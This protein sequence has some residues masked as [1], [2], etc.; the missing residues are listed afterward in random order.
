MGGSRHLSQPTARR[1]KTSIADLLRCRAGS[2]GIEFALVAPV[3]FILLSG[4]YDITQ[5][6]IAQRRVI[7]TAQ[8]IVEIATELS[9][10][11]NQTMSLTTT[12]AYQAETAIYAL[13]PGLKSGTD[14]SRF[15]VTLS[16]AVFTAT[17]AGCVAGVN[18]TYVANTAWSTPLPQSTTPVTRPCGVI[19]QV[20]PTQQ[21]TINNL[22][23]AGM[24]GLQ[25]I[26]IA[27]V[28][29]IYQPLFTGFVVGPVTL[30][31]TAFL[32]PRTGTAAQYIEYD[33]ANAA[34][35]PAICPGYL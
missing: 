29:Y 13:I 22:P 5:L 26:V 1:K 11:P 17:P 24:T 21:T 35:D 7:V 9:I 2:P 15:F 25:S 34:T 19:A 27:D 4:A 18:C 28:S 10:Q 14:T 30:Q 16:A 33:V 6:L 23:T 31:R 32:P 12:Q 8:E 20:A 3:M